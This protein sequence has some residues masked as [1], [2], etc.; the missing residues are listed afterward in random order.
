[1]KRPIIK[2][3]DMV[4]IE[5]RKTDG[6]IIK[7][8]NLLCVQA[9][10]FGGAIVLTS[11]LVR[12]DIACEIWRQ[13]KQKFIM[14]W[15]KDKPSE[16]EPKFVKTID[17]NTMPKLDKIGLSPRVYGVLMRN[18]YTTTAKLTIATRSEL[19]KV[20]GIGATA[21]NEIESVLKKKGLNL[22]G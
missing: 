10:E 15:S 20:N 16:A 19:Q 6:T 14:I 12:A 22:C 2:K 21:I 8:Q 5:A 17:N 4:R 7:S 9:D 13:Y 1:M 3:G 11:G 18:G